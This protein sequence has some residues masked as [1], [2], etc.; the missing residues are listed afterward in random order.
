MGTV[1]HYVIDSDCR[2]VS[3][4]FA[5]KGSSTLCVEALDV[6]ESA[7]KHMPGKEAER[8]DSASRKRQR[9]L[10]LRVDED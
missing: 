5:C 4:A 10:E 9:E 7:G 6:P 3:A 8:V 2:W 1:K